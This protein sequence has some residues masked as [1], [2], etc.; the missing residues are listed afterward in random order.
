MRSLFFFFYTYDVHEN[1]RKKKWMHVLETLNASFKLHT[2]NSS[3][4]C[5]DRHVNQNYFHTK[6]RT[7]DTLTKTISIQ[8]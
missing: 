4:V 2:L 5:H 8:K 1:E 3:I 7:T 6:V